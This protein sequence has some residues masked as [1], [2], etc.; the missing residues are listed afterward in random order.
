MENLEEKWISKKN[1]YSSIFPGND[2]SQQKK[3]KEKDNVNFPL[4][5]SI[6]H[7]NHV[8]DKLFIEKSKKKKYIIGIFSFILFGE[9]FLFQERQLPNEFCNNKK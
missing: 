6:I 7:G 9:D 1:E 4:I 3:K 8:F 5:W 2:I